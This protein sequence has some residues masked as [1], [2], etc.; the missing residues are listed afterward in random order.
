M[1]TLLFTSQPSRGHLNPMLTI[2]RQMRAKGHT[3][4]F[5]GTAPARIEKVVTTTGFRFFNFRPSLSTLGSSFLSFTSGYFETF[6]AIKLFFSGLSYYAQAIGRVLDEYQ[7]D[8]IVS[9]FSFIGSCLA[10]ESRGI[11]YVIIYHAG[12]S[13]KG[14]DIPPS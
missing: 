12:L 11:P 13:F 7:P 6:V 4:A 14:P 10:A 3:I 1:S 5:S 8:A 9:D 2:A